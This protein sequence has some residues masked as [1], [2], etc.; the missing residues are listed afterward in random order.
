MLP[1]EPEL[2]VSVFV[3]LQV[4]GLSDEL[5]KQLWMVLQRSMVTVRRD[6]TM[7]VSVVR[8]IEREVKIDRRMV[9]RKKQSGFIPPG[10]PKRWKDKMFEVLEG[11]VSTRIEGTQ[12]VTREADKM[13]L[14]R[15]LEITRK[16]VLD[17]LI[18]VKNLMVQCFPQHYNTFNR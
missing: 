12:S 7:L 18:V 14:V 10:R 5:A 4:Q 15:L 16:Y 9:D 2:R 6:P 17:D 1:S 13:W 11:T 8:I 3:D